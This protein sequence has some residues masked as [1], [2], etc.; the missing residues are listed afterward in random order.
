MYVLVLCNINVG[1]VT[2]SAEKKKRNFS[3]S[4]NSSLAALLMVTAD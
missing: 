4:I 2:D 3:D 1:P